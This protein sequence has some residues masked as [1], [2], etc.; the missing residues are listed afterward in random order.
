MR[1]WKSGFGVLGVTGFYYSGS[2]LIDDVSL[3]V[4]EYCCGVSGVLEGTGY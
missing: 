3:P 4:L 1:G 2:S